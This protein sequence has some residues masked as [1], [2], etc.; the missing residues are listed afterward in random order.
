MKTLAED[1]WK[2]EIL[3]RLMTV[4][5]DSTRRWGR[6]SAH[7]MIC[8][9]SDAFRIVTGQKSVNSVSGPF[10]RT[11]VKWIALYV[12]LRWP[13]GIP[14]MPE[15]DQRHGGTK[16]ADFAGDLAALRSLVELIA[17]RSAQ[18]DWPAHPF[19]GPMTRAAWLRWGY[20]HTDHHLRQFGQ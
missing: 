3:L 2:D 12:P 15:V 19:F 20:L 17:S 9:L 18:D 13:P 14:T 4:R 5:P 6:M 16:P 11:V 10:Q 1:R 7:Q 8:H